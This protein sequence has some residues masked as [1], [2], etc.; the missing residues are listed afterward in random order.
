MSISGKQ[1]GE[2]VRPFMAVTLTSALVVFTWKGTLSPEVIGT[3]A[4][5]IMAFYFGERSA[6]KQ[7][8]PSKEK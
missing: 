1:V 4:T 2:F 3:S 7:P 8:E 5:A 6:L